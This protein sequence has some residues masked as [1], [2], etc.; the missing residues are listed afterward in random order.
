MRLTWENSDKLAMNCLKHMRV[1]QSTYQFGI[2]YG[3]KKLWDLESP[4]NLEISCEIDKFAIENKFN[5]MTIW[6]N[7]LTFGIGMSKCNPKRFGIPYYEFDIRMCSRIFEL[8]MN[9]MNSM[10]WN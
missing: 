7:D 3:T 2:F 10:L 6:H 5:W 1:A 9:W 4:G 8:R